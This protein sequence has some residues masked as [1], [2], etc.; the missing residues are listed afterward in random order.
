[1][2]VM[3]MESRPRLCGL[4]NINILDI[5]ITILEGPMEV[6]EK[7][8]PMQTYV[9]CLI[10]RESFRIEVFF[11]H[12]LTLHR[13]LSLF[14]KLICCIVSEGAAEQSVS[15]LLFPM[16]QIPPA[17]LLHPDRDRRPFFAEFFQ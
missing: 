17:L 6:W 14:V 1:M 5:K 9:N 2:N 7:T 16:E 13:L 15:L 4:L 10:T 12:S 8:P 3:Y 11:P